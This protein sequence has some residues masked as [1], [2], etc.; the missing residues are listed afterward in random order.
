MNIHSSPFWE[1]SFWL[2]IIINIMKKIFTLALLSIMALAANAT[3]LFTGSQYVTWGQGLQ[4]QAEKFA[5]AKAGDLLM[6]TYTDATDGIELKVMDDFDRLPGSLQWCPIN[7]NGEVK[8]YLTSAAVAK[9]QAAGLEMIGNNFT[10]TKVELVDGKDNVTENTAW[11]GYFWM[12]DWSTLELAKSSF[13]GVNWADYKA[14]RFYSE[15]NR[16]DYVINVMTAWGDENKLGDQNTMTMT[17][18]YAELSL[19]GID[20]A[21][22]LADTDRL[23][24]QCNKEAGAPFNFTS[25]EL[26]KKVDPTSITSLNVNTTSE[27]FDLMGRKANATSKGILI[28]NGRKYISK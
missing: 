16:T 10:V 2:I 3:D 27:V 22:K 20:M 19:E 4:I 28:S 7:G 24:I 5:D 26:V 18:E 12:D 23:M 17:N 11:T 21:A 6:I 14:I 9:L 8:Q 13:N 1:G 15:A 25:I